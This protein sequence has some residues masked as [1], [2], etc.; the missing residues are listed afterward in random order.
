M[1]K[2][3]GQISR[4][5]WIAAGIGAVAGLIIGLI[6]GWGI[7]PVQ[8]YDA[9]ITNLRADLQ[10]D[11][12]VMSVQSYTRDH[13]AGLAASRFAQLGEKGPSYLEQLKN[14]AQIYGLTS[15]DVNVFAVAVKGGESVVPGQPNATVQPNATS[16]PASGTSSSVP[17]LLGAFCVILLLIGGLLVYLLLFR[18]RKPGLTRNVVRSTVAPI[19]SAAVS[20]RVART[21]DPAMNESAPAAGAVVPGAV[22][23]PQMGTS[24]EDWN[25]TAEYLTTYT[26]GNDTYEESFGI[27]RDDNGKFLGEC[28][29][30]IIDTIGVGEPKKVT[31]FEVWLFD[32]N[33]AQTITKILMSDH[34]FGDMGISQRLADKGDPVAAENGRLMLLQT[35]SLR[36]EATVESMEYGQGA[37]P[38]SSFFNQMTLRLRIWSKKDPK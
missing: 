17:V 18:N 22:V 30:A 31:A 34:A 29:V 13:N 33:D 21:V 20:S 2:F 27:E 10:Q 15:N 8:Y 11:Y 23:A 32:K 35:V 12:L 26:I 14:G 5:M 19:S 3:L 16:T 37:L 9:S 24:V 25:F 6:I 38:T 7:W 4:Q 28:G 36:L 1:N